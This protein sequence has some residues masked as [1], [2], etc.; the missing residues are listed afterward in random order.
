MPVAG[1]PVPFTLAACLAMAAPLA[2]AAAEP[3]PGFAW[4]ANAFEGNVSLVYGSTET[5]EDYVFALLCDNRNKEAELTVY[6]DIPG[7]KVGQAITIEISA[8]AAKLALKS[9]TETDQM[10][11]FIFGVAKPIAVKPVL[12]VLKTSGP[13]VVKMGKVTANLPGQGR[14]AA[15]AEFA[16]VCK[17]D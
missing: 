12:A 9:K 14:A 15:V 1:S 8:G 4:M 5:G 13:A 3:E 6:E 2:A 7:A 16:K 11:G 17:L 10:S